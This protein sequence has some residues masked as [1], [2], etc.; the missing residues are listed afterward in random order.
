MRRPA[1]RPLSAAL[2]RVVRSSQPATLLA[3]VQAAWPEVAGEV[4]AAEAQPV[5]ER[6]GTVSFTCSSAGWA[7]DMDL[8]APELLERLRERLPEGD[9]VERLRFSTRSGPNQL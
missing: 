5:S 2:D 8:F 6:D 1:P 4:F 3:R 9:R 7:Q